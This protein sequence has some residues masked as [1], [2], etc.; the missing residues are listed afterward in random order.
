VLVWRTNP[1]HDDAIDDAINDAIAMKH[2]VGG[3][4]AGRR[5]YV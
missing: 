2:R 1:E 4:E 3:G 5:A